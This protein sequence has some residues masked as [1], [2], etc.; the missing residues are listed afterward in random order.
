MIAD[1]GSLPEYLKGKILSLVQSTNTSEKYD[2]FKRTLELACTQASQ[3]YRKSDLKVTSKIVSLCDYYGK[4]RLIAIGDFWSQSALS[5]IHNDIMRL[6]R[7]MKYCDGT[8][9]IK[10]ILSRIQDHVQAGK[11]T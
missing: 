8:Y 9:N 5:V 4:T 2:D 10:P 3:L 1:A 6:L 11:P 7:Q